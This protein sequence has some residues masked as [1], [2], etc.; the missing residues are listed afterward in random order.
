MMPGRKHRWLLAVLLAFGAL[1]AVAGDDARE[2]LAR[3]NTAITTRNY[4][5]TFFRVRGGVVET[6]RIIHRVQGGAVTERLMS[7]DGSGR[8]F[9]SSGNE[10]MCYL[11]DQRAVLVEQRPADGVLMGNL[12]RFDDSTAAQYQMR[13]VERSRLM[14]RDAR[15]VEV[16]PRDEFRYGYR[17]WIDEQTAMPLKTQLCDG[18]GNVIEQVVFSSLELPQSIPDSAFQPQMSTDGFRW[19]RHAPRAAS[20]TALADGVGP[21]VLWDTMKLPPGFRVTSR[22][23]QLMPGS[24]APVAHVVLSDGI[25]SVS[26]F[27]EAKPG[28]DA[29]HKFVTTSTQVGSS[30][31][32]ATERDGVRVTAVGEVPAKTVQFIVSQVQQGVRAAANDSTPARLPTGPDALGPARLP[33]VLPAPGSRAIPSLAPRSPAL[34][35]PRGP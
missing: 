11:P 34:G 1:N 33:P 18:Q 13:Q 35:P 29:G 23:T 12:P 7:M 14:G 5:G 15:V 3:M 6:L 9:V 24:D 25:A 22:S 2:W 30:A 26:V 17:L 27:V 21:P 31:A 16:A 28:A 32:F 10:L 4:D 19:L 8:E 20:A